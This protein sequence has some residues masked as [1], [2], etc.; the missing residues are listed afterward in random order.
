VIT[1][2][3]KRAIETAVAMGFAVDD[4]IPLLKDVP[5]ALNDFV[6][7]NAEFSSL[8]EALSRN[9][10][11]G[12]YARKLRTL[13]ER[14]LEKI[15]EGGRLLVVSHGGVVEWSAI[16]CLPERARR[17]GNPIDKC[18]AVELAWENGIFTEVRTLRL[19]EYALSTLPDPV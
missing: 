14:E 7:D 12:R 6:P 16:A 8:F 15:P 17:L 4:T 19:S 18:E 10:D 13:F 11:A 3:K 2:P 5:E 9:A 1:S